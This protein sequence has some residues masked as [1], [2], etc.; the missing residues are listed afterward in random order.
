MNK[1]EYQ[2][3]KNLLENETTQPSTFRTKNWFGI[4]D[5]RHGVYKKKISVE[6]YNTKVKFMLSK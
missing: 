6:E 5:G 4:N 2:R 1:M 3:I